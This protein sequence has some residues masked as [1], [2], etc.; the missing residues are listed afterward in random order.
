MEEK[1]SLMV[2]FQV[3]ELLVI[4]A[5]AI[6]LGFLPILFW[7]MPGSDPGLPLATAIALL[8][9]VFMNVVGLWF[10]YH[11]VLQR[12]RDQY[13]AFPKPDYE[14]EWTLT[15][16]EELLLLDPAISRGIARIYGT[17]ALLLADLVLAGHAMLPSEGVLVKR[18]N[19]IV[20]VTMVTRAEAASGETGDR[21]SLD[22]LDFY[23]NTSGVKSL[24]RWLWW[25]HNEHLSLN[26]ALLTRL[27]QAGLIKEG[28]SRRFG[29]YKMPTYYLTDAGQSRSLRG[30]L[31]GMLSRRE[32]PG[33]PR[34]LFLTFIALKA[35]IIKIKDS[36]AIA[37]RMY[38]GLPIKLKPIATGFTSETVT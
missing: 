3:N 36:R 13:R 24:A 37:D 18:P 33:D 26:N 9:I 1:R 12:R 31:E 17:G 15:L 7:L 32:M 8:G 5:I 16:A 2:A 10:I 28:P 27:L 23:L 34:M 19:T 21:F 14:T 22:V 25:C 35:K 30:S 38:Y 29:L 6:P 4:D 20:L 11:V